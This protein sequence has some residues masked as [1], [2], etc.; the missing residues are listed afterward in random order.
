MIPDR[1]TARVLLLDGRDRI[2][3]MKG[4]LPGSPGLPAFW[5]TVGGGVEPGETYLEAAARE[6]REET[7]ILDFTLGPVV[8]LRE[9]VL[10]M[11]GPVRMVEQYIVARC[12]GAEP[13]RVGWD[14]LEREFIDDIRWWTLQ[15]LMTTQDGVFPPGLAR[16]LP[17]VLAGTWPAAPLAIPWA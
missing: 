2:L 6:I 5:F 1:P 13:D 9:G 11:P 4:R 17:D 12:E 14:A 10:H 3:L 8:W 7:G 16:L 15:E